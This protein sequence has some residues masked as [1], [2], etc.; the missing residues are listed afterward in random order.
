MTEFPFPLRFS[1][2]AGRA[3][4]SSPGTTVA[5]PRLFLFM[6]VRS[7]GGALLEAAFYSNFYGHRFETMSVVVN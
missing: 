6:V 7:H 2:V 4:V 5:L 3:S 1:L